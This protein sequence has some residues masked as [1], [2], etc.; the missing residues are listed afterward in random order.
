MCRISVII[1]TYNRAEDLKKCLC[2]ILTQTVR[3]F[4]VIV[5]DDSRDNKTLKMIAQIREKFREK[6]IILKYVKTRGR[7]KSLT[8]ARNI[9]V[10]LSKGDI[11]LFLDDDVILSSTYIEEITN[12]FRVCPQKVAAIGFITNSGIGRGNNILNKIFQLGYTAKNKAGLLVS[13]MGVYPSKNSS[14]EYIEC[15]LLTGSNMAIKR[16]VFSNGLKFDEKLLRYSYMEDC[17]FAASLREKYGDKPV[18]L[19]MR[20]TLIHLTSP[21]GRLLP[22]TLILMREAYNFYIFHKHNFNN[23][24]LNRIIYWWSRLGFIVGP[25]LAGVKNRNLRAR[26]KEVV[27]TLKAIWYVLRNKNRLKHGDLSEINAPFR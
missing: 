2:S 15:D 11:L 10:K 22:E 4:E 20:A 9:G 18:C 6:G 8:R 17:D 16:E 26:F 14:V 3:P 5:V 13:L 23:N 19:T 24:F 21:T 1:P 7:V 27:L 25:I 12:A